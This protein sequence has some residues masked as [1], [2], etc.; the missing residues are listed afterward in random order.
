MPRRLSYAAFLFLAIVVA[1]LAGDSSFGRSGTSDQPGLRVDFLDVG[2]GDAT[3]IR[4]PFG[5]S[6][7]IDGGPNAAVLSERLNEALGWN[8]RR[9][10]LLVLTHPHADHVDGLTGIFERYEVGRIL[11]TGVVHTAPGYLKWLA[12]AKDS[13]AEVVLARD[14]ETIALGPDLRLEVLWPREA[15]AGLSVSSLNDSSIVLRL[16]HGEA[17][18]LFTGDAE[19]GAESALVG[20]GIDLAAALLKV[21]HHG[22]NS[23]TGEE[24]VTA[25]RPRWAVISVGRDN[26][27][28]HPSPRVVNRLERAGA[29]VLRTDQAGSIGFHS[30]G[31]E[32]Q[33]LP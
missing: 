6:I 29:T 12:A 9:I 18:A 33:R 8:E 25:V 16:V 31:R 11:Y 2:Q 19:N 5:Q 3:L 1:W 4:T 23:A 10:D 17:A 30:D 15:L 20:S 26:P 32:W 28:D 14:Q 7:L 13:G 22:S 24:F 27:F 21:S